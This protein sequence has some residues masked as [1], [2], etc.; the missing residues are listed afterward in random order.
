M[1]NSWSQ[2][3]IQGSGLWFYGSWRHTRPHWPK[4]VACVFENVKLSQQND[5]YCVSWYRYQYN[6]NVFCSPIK[7]NFNNHAC[8][9]TLSS[10]ML[11]GQFCFSAA[12][13]LSQY[14]LNKA[15]VVTVLSPV[16]QK[17]NL[18][19]EIEFCKWT[20]PLFL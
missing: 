6:R 17:Q 19:M 11:S 18:N 5:R 10:K 8:G 16:E 20:L 7:C 15:S 2:L 3:V 13:I 4:L 9:L 1:L 12:K 14:L